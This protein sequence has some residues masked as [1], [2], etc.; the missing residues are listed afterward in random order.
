[1]GTLHQIIYIISTGEAFPSILF[2][3]L[4]DL[5]FSEFDLCSGLASL[6]ET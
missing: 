4:R 3:L 5:I 2:S 1:M 6:Q